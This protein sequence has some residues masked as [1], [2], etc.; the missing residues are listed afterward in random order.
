MFLEVESTFWQEEFCWCFPSEGLSWSYVERPCD[1][2]ELLLGEVI[3]VLSLGKVLAKQAVGVF[4][5]SSFPWA[6]GMG[7]VDFEACLFC[8]HA[9]LGHLTALVVGHGEAHLLVEAVEDV[10]EA[11]GRGF[12]AAVGEFD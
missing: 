5:D 6:M 11:L 2:I 12:G 4:T 3:E 8:D 1:L 7:E 9:V 10:T